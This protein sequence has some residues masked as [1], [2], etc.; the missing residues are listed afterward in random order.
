MR[1]YAT[2]ASG[3][4]DAVKEILKC[5]LPQCKI[6][7][8]LDGAVIF[9]HPNVPNLNFANNLFSV[10]DTTND[11]KGLNDFTR[12]LLAKKLPLGAAATKKTFRVV[13][14]RQ[15]QLVAVDNNLKQKLE[16]AI[17]RQT[18]LELNRLGG[19]TE[20][21]LLERSEGL[22]LFLQRLTRHKDFKKILNKGE[23][24][25][26][27]AFMLNFLSEPKEAEFYLDPF[28]G[29]GMLPSVRARDF[30][31]AQVFA[32]DTDK[33]ALLQLKQKQQND[34]RL[35]NIKVYNKDF[36]KCNFDGMIFD[37]IVTDPPW[38]KFD[39]NVNTDEFYERFF[40]KAAQLIKE[41]GILVLLT[42]RDVEITKFADGFTTAMKLDVLISGKKACVYKM[43]KKFD[44]IF[45][46]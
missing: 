30:A 32:N 43:I 15:N 24:H 42:A 13:T 10:I 18:G 31:P 20:F 37:K 29:G 34:R 5:T 6:I 35:E 36:F 40:A 22:T 16:Q 41:D 28:C 11:N 23:L 17:A 12:K 2:F 3:F 8:L 21:W 38:G 1:Y 45:I 33:N 46:T 27:I 14:S 7:N 44:K 39:G 26:P 25:P 9:E 4:Q 19:D